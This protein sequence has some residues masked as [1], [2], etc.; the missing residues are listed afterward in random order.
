MQVYHWVASSADGQVLAAGA[1]PGDLLVSRDGG[2]TWAAGTGLPAG[3]R[4]ISI[5]ISAN[6]TSMVAVAYAG[7]MFR[8]TD[9]GQT[10]TQIDTSFNT[11]G[12]LAYESVTIADD[13]L[14]IVAASAADATNPAAGKIYTTDDGGAT[15]A[16]V[17][18]EPTEYWRA[19]DSSA[20]GQVVV[21]ANHDGGVYVSNDFGHTFAALPISVGGAAIADGWYRLALS[22]DGA[23]VALA[24]NPQW[25]T[26]G[27]T[28]GIYIGR[29]AAGAWSWTQG[30]P[31]VGNYGAISMSANGDIIGASLYAPT[32]AGSAPGQV[33]ISTNH[34]TSFAPVTTPTGGVNW[35]GLAMTATG[36]KLLLGEGDFAT[37]PP[38]Q[39][40]VY[41]SSGTVGQ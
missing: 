17:T 21:A 25:G 41:L 24:G 7:G 4:W 28:T 31:V 6:G 5:D 32:A 10:W 23:T 34:G 29:N 30:S 14:H 15:W 27:P 13:G 20:T 9:S 12:G 1:L 16:T 39:G 11:G 35:R 40:H 37:S 18:G 22:R 33:L 36:S 2:A 19:V 3:G 8:S 38:S 26:G